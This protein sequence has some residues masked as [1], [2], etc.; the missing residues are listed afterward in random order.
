MSVPPSNY[1]KKEFFKLL[2]YGQK[3]LPGFITKITRDLVMKS[4]GLINQSCTADSIA[5]KSVP[6]GCVS[7]N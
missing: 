7:G 2:H 1:G 4:L 3:S 6:E 5:F